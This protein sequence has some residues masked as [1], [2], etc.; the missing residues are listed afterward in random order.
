MRLS[1]R[2][3]FVTG[4]NRGIGLEVCRQLGA[5]GAKVFL[6]VRRGG[7]DQLDALLSEGYDVALVSIDTSDSDSIRS[8]LDKLL[9]TGVDI[10]I[11]NA[12]VLD[13]GSLFSLSDTE[14]ENVVRT[15]LLGP[16]LLARNLAEGMQQRNWGRIVNVTSGMGAISRG[17]GADSVA[18]RVTK[19][20][21][22]GFTICLAEAL[23]GTGVLVNSVDPG[24]VRTSMGG[25]M[26]HRTPEEGARAILQAVLLP[27]SGPSGVFFR[28]GRKVDW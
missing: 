4:A 18:Y 8:A 24:W 7:K 17:L 28:D 25:P 1:R 13:R 27:D 20:A 14:V 9:E 22:N 23:R 26:A 21:L 5:E 15:N 6:G 10:L 3:A 16:M 2:T 12:A 19:L 11:N